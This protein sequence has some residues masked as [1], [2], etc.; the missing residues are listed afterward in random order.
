MAPLTFRFSALILA[1]AVQASSLLLSLPAQA[2]S[3][4]A[5]WKIDP[6]PWT[7]G[8]IPGFEEG[9]K[10]RTRCGAQQELP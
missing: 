2:A 7:A 6:H 8:A 1:A 3:A 9:L 5:A 10:S 4:L